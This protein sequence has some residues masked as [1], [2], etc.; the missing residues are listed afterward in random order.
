M[1]SWAEHELCSARHGN[2]RLNRRLMRLVAALA[3]QPTASV[4]QACGSRAATKGAYRFWRS[5][6]VT[7]D[8]IRAAQY[9]ATVE[10][11]FADSGHP[12]H[13]G[14]ER[15]PSSGH[16]RTG[17]GGQCKPAG[18]EGS[19]S[20][21]DEQRRGAVGPDPSSQAVWIRDPATRGN[22][23]RWRQRETTDKERQRW[24]TAQAATQQ[25][26]PPD[27]AVITVA[28]REA[29]IYDVFAAP[30]RPGDQLPIR[31]THHRRVNHAA[32]YLWQAIRC[33]P[34]CSHET[35]A[36]P[37]TNNRALRQVPITVRTT[38]PN[39]LPP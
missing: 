32:G 3:A 4:P 30:R 5:E 31:V 13:H 37:R 28:D 1:Q 11:V 2:A 36:V 9:H 16:P 39:I 33:S 17:I 29:D 8:A 20:A 23:H 7:L 15:H 26:V 14:A 6:W 21:R 10:R 12:G 18:V 34:M 19:L 22:R 27:V 25:A 38:P 35:I 24:L